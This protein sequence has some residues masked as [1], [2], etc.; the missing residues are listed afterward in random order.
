MTGNS[1]VGNRTGPRGHRP[2]QRVTIPFEVAQQFREVAQK[3]DLTETITTLLSAWIEERKQAMHEQMLE[4]M[5]VFMNTWPA[6]FPGD[7]PRVLDVM[8]E[9]DLNEDEAIAALKEL[10]ERHPRQQGDA[11]AG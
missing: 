2:L 11:N 7:G 10:G 5:W 8:A 9:F 1:R 4:E 6:R 3:A